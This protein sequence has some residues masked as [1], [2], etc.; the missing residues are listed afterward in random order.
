MREEIRL[1]ISFETPA[2][3]ACAALVDDLARLAAEFHARERLPPA[4]RSN[5]V[6]SHMERPKPVF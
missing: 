3:H 6:P 5:T 4:R 1:V 2:E